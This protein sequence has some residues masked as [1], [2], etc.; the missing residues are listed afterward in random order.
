[1]KKYKRRKRNKQKIIIITSICSL[2]LI[3][4]IG[5]A[6]MN[7]NLEINAKGNIVEK[8]KVIQSWTNNSNEDF[9]TDY[10]RENIVSATF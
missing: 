8:S 10:Y 6:A 7:T 3:M 2:L 4:S 9:H 1:M 5:Y